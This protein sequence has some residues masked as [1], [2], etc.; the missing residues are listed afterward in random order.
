MFVYFLV[1]CLVQLLGEFVAFH[2][3]LFSIL[4]VPAFCFLK[5]VHSML[6]VEHFSSHKL[7]PFKIIAIQ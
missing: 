2:N 1:Y 3:E 4:E 7:F 5:K 6:I